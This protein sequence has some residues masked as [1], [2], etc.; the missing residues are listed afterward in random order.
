MAL[1]TSNKITAKDSKLS[2]LVVINDSGKMYEVHGIVFSPWAVAYSSSDCVYTF[3]E[4]DQ[5]VRKFGCHGDGPCQ[6]N[7]PRGVV[8]DEDNMLYVTD[9]YNH[10]IHKF[11][12]V[13]DN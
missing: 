2:T 12:Q 5:L 4:Q 1:S 3:N 9:D 11:Y 6:F 8:F 7:S 10:R 13:T